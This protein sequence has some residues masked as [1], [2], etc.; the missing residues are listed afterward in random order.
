VIDVSAPAQIRRTSMLR[1]MKR[2]NFSSLA[3][4][5]LLAFAA[6]A[7]ALPAVAMP[8]VQTKSS[9]RRQTKRSPS[10]TKVPIN[11]IGECLKC[12][13]LY[14]ACIKKAAATDDGFGHE[15]RNAAFCD[16]GETYHNDESGPIWLCYRDCHARQR[17]QRGKKHKPS[18]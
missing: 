4:L 7:S 5:F 10:Q 9:N 14:E 2:I 11:G 15:G 1:T 18:Q 17:Q 13:A 8:S 6:V 16:P 12:R 3:L